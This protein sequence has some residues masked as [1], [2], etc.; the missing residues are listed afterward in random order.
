MN[1]TQLVKAIAEKAGLS[2]NDAGKA[3][4]ALMDV[5]NDTLK[6]GDKIQIIGFGTFM[7]QERP[8]RK[9][10]NPRTGKPIK[11]PAKKVLKFKASKKY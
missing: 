9:G 7:M 6:N 4:K 8:A 3:F 11:I 2:K 1:K 10:K 5:T